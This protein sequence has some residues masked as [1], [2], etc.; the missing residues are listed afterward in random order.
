MSIL[1]G[2]VSNNVPGLDTQFYLIGYVTHIN[3]V[4]GET[5]SSDVSEV[6]NR[7]DHK[8]CNRQTATMICPFQRI[9]QNVPN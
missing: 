2:C 7:L 1:I 3:N 6:V 8:L 9:L 5:L 4:P